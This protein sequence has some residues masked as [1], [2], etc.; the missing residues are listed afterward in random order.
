MSVVTTIK[1]VKNE[2]AEEEKKPTNPYNT[3]LNECH[4]KSVLLHVRN[5]AQWRPTMVHA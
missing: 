5:I 2:Q 1:N 4:V 3:L